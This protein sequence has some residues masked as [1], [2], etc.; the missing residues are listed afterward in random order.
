MKLGLHQNS[1]DIT[2]FC[3]AILVTV[4]LQAALPFFLPSGT[5]QYAN[6]YIM[7]E[8]TH[9]YSLK[10]SASYT[11]LQNEY[12]SL[13]DDMIIEIDATGKVRVA[14]ETSRYHIC[15]LQG[16]VGTPGQ[17][18]VCAPNRVVI[19]IEESGLHE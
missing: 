17:P 1:S 13:L 15:S 7:G 14:E 19:V 16:W 18:I 10:E 2:Y 8:L 5:A 11:L 3:L 6:V 12:P 9:S 4:V